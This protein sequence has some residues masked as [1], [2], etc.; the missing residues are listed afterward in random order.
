MDFEDTPQEAEFR[1]KARAWLE[2]NAPSPEEVRQMGREAAD[3]KQAL[4]RARAWQ[5]K[6]ADAGWAC[7]HWPKE[8]G[9]MAATPIERVIWEQEEGKFAVPRGFFDIG[10]GMC[11]PTM[12]AYATEEQKKRYLPVMRRGEEIWCQLFSEPAG[13]SDVAGLRTRAERDGDDWI[14]NGQ[15]IWTSG[16]H[17]SDY[18]ILVTRSDPNVPKH[19]GL[20][21][22]FLDMKSPGVT[23]KPIKQ[24]SGASGFNEVFF[25]NVRIPDSQRL[26]KVGDGWKVSLTT[27]MNERLSVGDAPPPGFDEL[28]A[29]AKS[30]E[31]DGQP[32]LAKDDVRQKL[33][34]WYV[35]SRGLKYTKFRTYTAL[36]RGQTP[37]PESSITKLV[38]ASNLQNISSFGMDL[39]DQGGVM[40]DGET[41]PAGGLFQHGYL[42]S[43]GLRIAGGTDEILRNIIAERVLGLPPD[44]R[45]DKDIPFNKLPV[46][47]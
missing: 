25:D 41:M 13:G 37:G 12:M 23:V 16:A 28:F 36:S 26:G 1:A 24:I 22:F 32:A 6:K 31:I 44:I 21:F 4:A 40:T 19:Q 2:A 7:M 34:D 47:K 18:G 45:V 15:K 8:Y 42:F 33:A 11:G 43:P 29:L 46:G 20:T 35:Q 17:Y 38:S 14:I 9:G 30:V 5:A 39:V 3:E 27:L 10:L